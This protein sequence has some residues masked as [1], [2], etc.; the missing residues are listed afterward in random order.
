[1]KKLILAVTIA[2]VACLSVAGCAQQPKAA[3]SQEAIEQAKALETAEAQAKYLISQANA[4]VNSK[5]FD[6][7][8]QTAKYVLA[9]L[10]SESK[11]AQSIIEKAT[12]QLK[13]MAEEKAAEMKKSLSSMGQ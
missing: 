12:T 1:M 9:N 13:K 6:Q 5:D 4:F 7:A 8:I 11:E 10:D 2:G 3:N